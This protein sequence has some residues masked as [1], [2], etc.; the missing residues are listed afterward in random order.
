MSLNTRLTRAMACISPWPRIGLSTYIVCRQGASKPVSHMS[1]TM[2]IL[3]GSLGSLKRLASSSRR[4]LL[5]MC[6]C[7]S[8]G[9]D[10]EPVITILMMPLS[11]SSW[12][13]SGRSADDG[14]VEVDANPPAHAHDHRLAVHRFQAALEVVDQV[15]GNQRDALLRA[16]QG[17]QRG[18]L[19]LELFL[20]LDFLALGGFLEVFVELRPLGFVELQFRQPA[21][22]EDG[23]RGPVLHG[24]LDVVNA[25]V[26]AE[27]GPRVLV[28]QLD[29]RA[30]E[31]DERCLGQGLAHVPGEA[32]DEV[33]LA[34][35]GLVGDDHDVA[36]VRKQR[37]LVLALRSGKNFCTV[38]NTTP[39]DAVRRSS[40]RWARLCA[41]TGCCRSSS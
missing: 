12:C 17:L 36:P 3:N 37:V 14:V 28:G 39:P 33:V 19:G 30:G 41:C 18:P 31:A 13:Q 35:V 34:A 40:R 1:R 15:L 2:T 20:V 26:V 27:H 4:G 22:V 11:S 24:P 10:A 21:F 9:S 32:V 29:G 16:D 23:D 38:V 8:S 6:G 5:R 25:D 7:Q